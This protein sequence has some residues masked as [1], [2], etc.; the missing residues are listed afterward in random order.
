MN[1]VIYE[2][3]RMCKDTD[4]EKNREEKINITKSTMDY[5]SHV[6]ENDDYKM[7]QYILS[8]KNHE[9]EILTAYNKIHN[10][11][12]QCFN[13]MENVITDHESI[14]MI[15]CEN[16]LRMNYK[17]LSSYTMLYAYLKLRDEPSFHDAYTIVNTVP[18][19]IIVICFN[20]EDYY[21][22]KLL[23][24]N[25]IHRHGI[26]DDNT[27]KQI[28]NEI[29][30][31]WESFRYIKNDIINNCIFVGENINTLL[32]MLEDLRIK[33]VFF[34]EKIENITNDINKTE[35]K[36]NVMYKLLP[37]TIY[38]IGIVKDTDSNNCEKYILLKYIVKD[39]SNKKTILFKLS[40]EISPLASTENIKLL[41]LKAHVNEITKNIVY[42]KH[43]NWLSDK[44][45]NI[46]I[47]KNDNIREMLLYEINT[48]HEQEIC[49][50]MYKF[51]NDNMFYRNIKKFKLLNVSSKSLYNNATIPVKLFDIL[52]YSRGR[53]VK[54]TECNDGPYPLI[55]QLGITR[56][57]DKYVFNGENEKYITITNRK[58]YFGNAQHRPYK[59]SIS[60]NVTTFKVK[61]TCNINPYNISYSINK[62]IEKTTTK[63]TINNILQCV[64]EVFN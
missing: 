50:M 4:K 37:S 19:N 29:I 44:Q 56:Y 31:Y 20:K 18:N 42:T 23:L 28:I 33:N 62:F 22:C 25:Y 32:H 13:I 14:I 45:D 12:K 9:E 36:Y 38:D 15:I 26:N 61:S 35:Y 43:S 39:E 40:H 41:Q 8:L 51:Y 11:V 3:V 10:K 24:Y 1:N 21:S 52:E 27:V 17:D 48:L 5:I 49:K 53:Q 46:L 47:N 63:I 16:I 7:S 54:A 58:D 6:F 30:H 55:G 60:R 57:I 2:I 59:F 64:V 34:Y